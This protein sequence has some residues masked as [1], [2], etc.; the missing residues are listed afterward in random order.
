MAEG[1][2]EALPCK[3]VDLLAYRRSRR[4]PAQ[5]SNSGIA[6]AGGEAHVYI[7]LV[8]GRLNYGM[9]DVDG[10]NA[11]TL[12]EPLLYLSNR[13]LQLSKS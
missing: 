3:V 6:H 8:D 7:D 2:A 11:L 1:R 12:L 4:P 5:T 13:I 10:T 9:V